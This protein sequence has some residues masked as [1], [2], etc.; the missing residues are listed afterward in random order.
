MMISLKSQ[1]TFL[2]S[3]CNIEKTSA[4]TTEAP[5]AKESNKILE[6]FKQYKEYFFIGIGGTV[7]VILL[8]WLLWV[9]KK[10]RKK[11]Q[12]KLL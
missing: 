12:S 3:I 5:T 1:F 11:R 9:L 8:V 10:K 2:E 6:F 7:G 4:T